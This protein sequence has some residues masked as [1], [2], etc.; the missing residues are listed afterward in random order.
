MGLA[1]KPG[2]T[3]PGA[4][5]SMAGME[6]AIEESGARRRTSKSWPL[7]VA[8]SPLIWLLYLPLY[9]VP[10]FWVPPDRLALFASL[11]GLCLFLPLYLWG[12]RRG[13]SDTHVL[14]AAAAILILSAALTPFGGTWSVVSIYA[15]AMT[16]TVRR[17]RYAAVALAAYAAAMTI[18][19]LATGQTWFNW[20]FALLLGVMAGIA[21]MSRIAL[22][23][24]NA[25]LVAAQGEV[26]TLAEIAERERIARDLHDL[27]GRSLTLVAVKAELADKLSSRDPAAAGKEMR[28]VA[29]VARD[30]LAEVRAAVEG[31]RG[32]SLA[33]EIEASRSALAV[34]GVAA[35]VDG[36]PDEI[37]PQASAVL[38]MA[39]REAVTNVIRHASAATCRISAGAGSGMAWLTVVD[40]GRGG[41]VKEGSGLGGMRARIGAAGGTMKIDSGP[42]G[43]RLSATVPLGAS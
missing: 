9:A 12:S 38:A 24:K 26:R 10:W 19:G 21:N 17:P 34:V 23:A 14:A 41:A 33:H 18:F 2:L 1:A 22:E 3:N 16:G 42:A 29:G 39:L 7:T 27:L 20:A 40:D 43:T 30:A 13:L 36:S 35:H 25:A 32:A 8:D 15:A 31:M 28:E 4:E 6:M 5:R 11:A 37:A